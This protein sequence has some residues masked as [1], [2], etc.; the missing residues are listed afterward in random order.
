MGADGGSIPRRDELVRTRGRD[1]SSAAQ[2]P[3]LLLRALWTLCALSRTS[4]SKPI[5]SDAMGRLYNK[6]A[7]VRFLLGRA[8]PGAERDPVDEAVAGHLKGLKDLREL[9]LEPNPAYRRRGSPSSSSSSADA[10]AAAAAADEATGPFPFVCAL[11]QK[12][13]NGKMRFVYLRSCGCVLAESGLR[14]VAAAGS[15][16]APISASALTAVKREEGVKLKQHDCPLC[17]KPFRASPAFFSNKIASSS[18]HLGAAA[19]VE[20]DSTSTSA[21]VEAALLRYDPSGDIVPLNPPP[22]EQEALRAAFLANRPTTSSKKRKAAAATATGVIENGNGNSSVAAGEE[23]N[24]KGKQKAEARSARKAAIAQLSA[25]LASDPPDSARSSAS[26]PAVKRARTSGPAAASHST[27]APQ[28]KKEMSA[29]VR[30]IYGLDRPK[31][32][33]GESWMVRGTFNRYA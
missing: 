1:A 16:S 21:E 17:S 27:T 20:E 3:A 25:E 28:E 9:T 5:V 18:S 11:T 32:P 22:A 26:S 10:A 14:T 4:L 15:S 30:S 2:D 33:K 12:E 7:V 24:A 23:V 8:D 31:D 6:E 19:A 29:A 13:L